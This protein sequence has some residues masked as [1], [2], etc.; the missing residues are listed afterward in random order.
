M[1]EQFLKNKP[2]KIKTEP[3]EF[4]TVKWMTNTEKQKIYIKFVS[5]LNNH[6]KRS[7]WTENLYKHIHTH[8]DFIAHY[9]IQGFYHE[10]FETAATFHSDNSSPT[11]YAI[12]EEIHNKEYGIGDF[13]STLLNS[14]NYGGNSDYQDL[15]DALRDAAKKY[16]NTWEIEINLAKK[17]LE[18]FK[19]NEKVIPVLNEKEEIDRKIEELAKRSSALNSE[20]IKE[21]SKEEL[22]EEIVVV[23]SKPKEPKS[24]KIVMPMHTQ[25]SLFDFTY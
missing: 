10:Y 19:S 9:D 18:K 12:Y 16:F 24:K 25:P 14:K 20:L 17:A 21:A 5:F 22:P 3:I 11:F 13:L 4:E 6:F 15:D 1:L 8:C 2:F 23:L 7:S